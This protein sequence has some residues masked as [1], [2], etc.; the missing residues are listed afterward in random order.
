M[1]LQ[2]KNIVYLL[3]INYSGI[4]RERPSSSTKSFDY[5]WK[6]DKFWFLPRSFH[7]QL[8][9]FL[10]Y[11]HPTPLIHELMDCQ[12]KD[13][14]LSNSSQVHIN[15]KSDLYFLF[16]CLLLSSVVLDLQG[17]SCFYWFQLQAHTFW[18][19]KL[20][21]YARRAQRA[22]WADAKMRWP[23]HAISHEKIFHRYQHCI[24]L[25]L[26]HHWPTWLNLRSENNPF[27]FIVV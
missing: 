19:Q 22:S 25:L 21:S 26:R 18:R 1:N 7:Y 3:E 24:R 14:K 12:R 8:S 20:R 11:L 9:C 4:Y 17:D 27:S 23:I 15:T 5:K 2:S 6:N 13:K 16:F 10:L